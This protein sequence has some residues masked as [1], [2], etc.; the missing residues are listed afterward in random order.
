[1]NDRTLRAILE[2]AAAK[3]T[4]ETRKIGDYYGSCMDETGIDAKGV[5]PLE[6]ELTRIA[7]LANRDGLPSVLAMLHAVGTPGFLGVTSL[8]DIENASLQMAA[9]FPSGLG[10]PDRDYYFRD[11]ARSVELRRQY[12][13]HI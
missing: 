7:T 10:L 11:D 13:V 8:P 4:A 2:Q 5:Q 9:V 1:R 6:S 12:V 3:P